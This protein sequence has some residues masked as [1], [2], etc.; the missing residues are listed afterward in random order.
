MIQKIR[1]EKLKSQNYCNKDNILHQQSS[2]INGF[3]HLNI[4]PNEFHLKIH[5]DLKP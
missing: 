1:K 5:E 4:V 2:Q 3:D